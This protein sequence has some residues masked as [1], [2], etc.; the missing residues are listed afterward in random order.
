MDS[1]RAD[2]TQLDLIDPTQ[3]GS[4]LTGHPP[5]KTL[6]HLEESALKS[7][8]QLSGNFD[9]RLKAFLEPISVAEHAPS[10]SVRP[11]AVTPVGAVRRHRFDITM[12][13]AA[14]GN[15][16]LVIGVTGQAG[17]YGSTTPE[18]GVFASAGGGWWSNIGASI[19][20]TVTF[21]FGPPSDMDGVSVGI[22]CDVSATPGVGWSVSG[23]LLYGTTG[24]PFPFLGF[25][26]GAAFGVAPIRIDVTLQV[27]VTAHKPLLV[28]K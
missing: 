12:A 27:T 17:V 22:G 20:P 3:L 4:P 13:V 11:P 16:F 9:S 15:A 18:V 8:L 1:F 24:P 25:S 19:G 14:E 6:S 2:L 23:M 10:I 28:F 21:I 7:G 5:R 26:V